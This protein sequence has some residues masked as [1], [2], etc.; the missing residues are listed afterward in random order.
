MKKRNPVA[1]ALHTPRFRTQVVADKR[2]RANK[3]KRDHKD[4]E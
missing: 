4:S 1:K 3:H 2:K